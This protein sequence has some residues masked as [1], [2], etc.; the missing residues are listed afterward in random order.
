MQSPHPQRSEGSQPDTKTNQKSPKTIEDSLRGLWEYIK[1]S[2]I[3]I[4]RVLEGKDRQ[5][6]IENL[7]EKTI[8]ENFPNP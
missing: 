5:Q 3:C 8:S 7:Y 1:H 6:N 4:V 2:N